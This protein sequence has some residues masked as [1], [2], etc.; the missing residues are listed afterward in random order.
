M[1]DRAARWTQLRDGAQNW[2]ER[3]RAKVTDLVPAWREIDLDGDDLPQVGPFVLAA[4]RL[5]RFDASLLNQLTPATL[6]QIEAPAKLTPATGRR[7]DPVI[8][9][10]RQVLRSSGLVLCFPEGDPSPDGALHRGSLGFG[11]LVI[12]CQVP[13]IPIGVREAGRLVRVG[14]ALDFSRYAGLSVD[15]TLAR[16][17]TDTVVAA[18]AD[19]SGQTYRDTSVG[20]ARQELN[21]ATRLAAVQRR[22]NAAAGRRA[23]RQAIEDRRERTEAERRDLQRRADRAE[24]LARMHAALAAEREA[25]SATPTGP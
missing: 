3:A 18:V 19:L 10:A 7:E 20:T 1:V 21:T 17:V 23:F 22:L 15:R 25:E 16:A 8:A 4:N 14:K 6:T 24:E 12:A 11:A 13:V 5:G 9:K 2:T